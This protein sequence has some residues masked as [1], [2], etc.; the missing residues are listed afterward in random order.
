[1]IKFIGDYFDRSGP[2]KVIGK[3][4]IFDWKAKWTIYVASGSMISEIYAYAEANRDA[5]HV[6]P[7]LEELGLPQLKPTPIYSD[8]SSALTVLSSEHAARHKGTKHVERRILAA[9]QSHQL[10]IIHGLFCPSGSNCADLGCTYKDKANFLTQRRTLHG[11]QIPAPQIPA[12][13]DVEEKRPWFESKP[14]KE[15]IPFGPERKP[16]AKKVVTFTADIA[17]TNTKRPFYF[18]NEDKN[19]P[20]SSYASATFTDPNGTKWKSAEHF[21]QAAKFLDPSHAKLICDADTAS[22][23]VLFASMLLTKYSIRDNWDDLKYDVMLAATT[24]KFNSSPSLRRKLVETSPRALVERSH[25][26]YWGEGKDK[27]GENM[28]GKILETVRASLCA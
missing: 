28:Y 11:Y 17:E 9:I 14:P 20:L 16:V 5:L 24:A 10:C 15:V 26:E 13:K 8:C 23:A 2:E 22:A 1:V 12:Y 18:S 21:Y 7:F 27:K 25:D 6:R 19:E 3:P 4:A